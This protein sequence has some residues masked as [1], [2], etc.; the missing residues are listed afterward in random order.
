[1]VLGK[2][3]EGCIFVVLLC[4]GKRRRQR[5]KR[6]RGVGKED[7]GYIFVVLLCWGS[8][9]VVLGK[10]KKTE[11]KGFESNRQVIN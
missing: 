7:R 11:S 10:K 5:T 6:L 4:W 3:T 1:M 2:K 9:V 8:G